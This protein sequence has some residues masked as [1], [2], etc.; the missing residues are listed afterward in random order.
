MDDNEQGF[1]PFI[2]VTRNGIAP[3]LMTIA[4]DIQ[5]DG[6]LTLDASSGVNKIWTKWVSASDMIAP[7]SNGAATAAL[8]QSD[9]ITNVFDFDDNSFESVGFQV[10]LGDGYDG[11]QIT[12]S[13][14]WFS[15]A[16]TS[17]DVYFRLE[18]AVVG[19]SSS[20]I[21][22]G[23]L[24]NHADNETDATAKDITITPLSSTPS[25]SG[26]LLI[27]KLSRSGV[28]DDMVGDMRLLG[29]SIKYS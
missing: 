13:P 19:D 20:T 5:F 26:H 16:A 8:Q 3:V 28:S 29:C 9:L 12:V 17:G 11:S 22:T 4:P 25:G 23:T 24:T 27:V 6:D 15:N 21:V 2:T 7:A 18:I 14:Y 10:E 1:S